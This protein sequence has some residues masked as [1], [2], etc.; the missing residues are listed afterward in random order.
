MLSVSVANPAC[1][2]IAVKTALAAFCALGI[3]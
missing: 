3:T 1:A 2:T